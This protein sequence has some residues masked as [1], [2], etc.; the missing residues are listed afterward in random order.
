LG[1]QDDGQK[2]NSLVEI[3]QYLSTPEN[4]LSTKEFQEFWSTLTEEE[5]HEFKTTELK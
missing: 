3:K 2:E 4:P 5:K 1:E